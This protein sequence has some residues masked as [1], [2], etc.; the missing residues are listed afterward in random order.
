MRRLGQINIVFFIE[1]VDL[2]VANFS[3]RVKE[4]RDDLF[5]AVMDDRSHRAVMKKIA[6][7][8]GGLGPP[9]QVDRGDPAAQAG[10]IDNIIMDERGGVKDLAGRPQMAQAGLMFFGD[11]AD[12]ARG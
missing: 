7:E 11:L 8:D 1:L 5:V 4:K 3:G 10:G 12:A 9:L 6:D 2:A